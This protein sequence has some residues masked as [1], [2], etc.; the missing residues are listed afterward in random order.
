MQNL[1]ILPAYLAFKEVWRNRARFLLV[2]MVIALITVLVLFIAGLGEGLG[3]G[4]REYISKLDAQLIVY[5]AKSD[6][7]ISGSRLGRDRLAAVRRVEGVQAAGPAAFTNVA[8]LLPDKPLPLK[9]ALIGVDP[10]QP[11]EPRVT[12]GQQLSTDLAEEVLIDRNVLLRSS[13]KIG[14][15]I[16]IRATQG[17]RDEFFRLRVVGVTEGQ[18]YFLQPSIMTPY[19]TWDRI[20]PKSEAEISRSS[21]VS[22]VILVRLNEPA[23]TEV[24]RQRL[25]GEVDN[26]EVANLKTAIEALPGYTAQQSTINTQ[27]AFTL[28]IGVLVIGGFFQIQILQ[29][30]AQ[31]GV[32]K[33]IGASNWVV[34]MAAVLQIVIITV[35]GVAIGGAGTYLLALS[36][37]PTVPISFNGASTA[38]AVSAL[39]LIGPLGGLVSVRYA[40]QIEPLKALGLSS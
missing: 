23:E 28:L 27:G 6:Y 30:V 3:N 38:F 32:L 24:M 35:L 16:T 17:T 4:N 40:I 26:I 1:I 19:F 7:A 5:Q 22:N 39:L 10:G 18:Q 21:Y 20:R 31:I 12:D 36:F 11:G 14:D 33:A 34:G 25:M 2:S 13:I 9:V 8:I 37:P 15:F 29:K